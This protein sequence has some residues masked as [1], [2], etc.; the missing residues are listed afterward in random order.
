MAISEDL[1]G[2][3][4]AVTVGGNDLQEY[5]DDTIEE[6]DRTTTR[7]VEAKSGQEFA[8]RMKVKKRFG[9]AAGAD[10]LSFRITVDGDFIAHPLIDRATT[11]M[12]D[13]SRKAEGFQTPEGRLRKCKFTSLET[14]QCSQWYL[15]ES[16]K[17]RLS[18]Q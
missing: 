7:Y 15:F 14:G 13:A 18:L 17:L 11:R 10:T 3:E 12:Q 8:I 1:P 4:V 2:V 6:E 5:R 9:Y 16:V